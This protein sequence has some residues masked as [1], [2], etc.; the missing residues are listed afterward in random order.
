MV[1]ETLSQTGQSLDDT[2]NELHELAIEFNDD[3]DDQELLRDSPVHTALY[4]EWL[5]TKD[6][7]TGNLMD[8]EY[9]TNWWDNMD[10]TTLTNLI[11]KWMKDG[12]L[13]MRD[14][15]PYKLEHMLNQDRNI[16]S[17]GILNLED[18]TIQDITN[19]GWTPIKFE[20]FEELFDVAQL[21]IRIRTKLSGKKAKSEKPFHCTAI[22]RIEFDNTERWKFR[23]G[24][25]D[26]LK[27]RT[28]K[29]IS[30]T[31]RENKEFYVEY[32]NKW[33]ENWGREPWV[34]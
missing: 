8:A 32:L 21:T 5:V 10:K 34:Y 14:Q 27:R 13:K 26:I 31:L 28:I 33:R 25:L 30:P 1:V 17:N 2:N 15:K 4:N 3:N 22:W 12:W 20:T 7:H 23:K 11:I 9:K 16:N 6:T 24:D 18:K 19:D 29:E